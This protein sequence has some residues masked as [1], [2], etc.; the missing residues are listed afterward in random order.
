MSFKWIDCWIHQGCTNI[1]ILDDAYNYFDVMADNH[2]KYIKLYTTLITI[3]NK[4]LKI[5]SIV[6]KAIIEHNWKP[7]WTF[8]LIPI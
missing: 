5:K 7:I 3:K 2:A 6:S 1:E 8:W 4:T